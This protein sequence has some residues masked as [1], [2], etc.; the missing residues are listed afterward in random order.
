MSTI[1]ITIPLLLSSSG[2]SLL[3]RAKMISI[4]F[5]LLFLFHMFYVFVDIHSAFYRQGSLWVQQGIRMHEII[6]YTPAKNTLFSWLI[7]FFNTILKFPV[8]VGIW[9]GLVSYYKKSDG[10][11]WIRRLF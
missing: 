6:S 8:A 1:F 11:H 9:I 7:F 3:N 4:G 5:C 10:Q 2:I